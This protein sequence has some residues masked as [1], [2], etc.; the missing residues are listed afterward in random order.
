[1]TV[2][3]TFQCISSSDTQVIDTKTRRTSQLLEDAHHSIRVNANK[4]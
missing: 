3:N 2:E 1:M 4:G